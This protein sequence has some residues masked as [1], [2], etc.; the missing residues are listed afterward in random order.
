MV[1][2]SIPYASPEDAAHAAAFFEGYDVSFALWNDLVKE[3]I[4]WGPVDVTA[5]KSRVCLKART[6]FLWCP[7]AHKA[8]SIFVRFWSSHPHESSTGLE[9][10]NDVADDGRVSVRVRLSDLSPEALGWF[11]DAYRFDV[12]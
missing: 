7:Q 8:G 11:R 4:T 12:A 6:R 9:V 10:R 2:A 3:A 1:N 5:T